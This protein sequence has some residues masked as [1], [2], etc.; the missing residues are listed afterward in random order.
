MTT[1]IV[2]IV[3]PDRT[4]RKEVTVRDGLSARALLNAV[5]REVE[6]K[7]KDDKDWTRWNLVDVKK[8]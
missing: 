2:D 3:Y 8:E 5:D 4:E 1:V 7:F 6:K